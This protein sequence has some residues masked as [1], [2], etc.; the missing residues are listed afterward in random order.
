MFKGGL[1]LSLIIFVSHII[2]LLICSYVG[3]KFE[4]KIK[5]VFFYILI[6]I[7]CLYMHA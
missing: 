5:I 6:A 2:C 1:V 4:I 3:R 7:K